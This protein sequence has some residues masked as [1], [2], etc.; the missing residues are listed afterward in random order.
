MEDPFFAAMVRHGWKFAR[1]TDIAR[2]NGASLHAIPE[3]LQ[4]FL[5]SYDTLTS[6]D[7]TTWLNA[8][9]DFTRTTSADGFSWDAFEL[10]SL[11]EAEGD[12]VWQQ[13]IQAFW[14]SHLPIL[15]S[16]DGHYTYVAYCLAGGNQGRYVQ[17]SEPE[18][19]QVHVV[20][21]SLPEFK[22]WLLSSVAGPGHL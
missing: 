16:V 2:A 5:S 15:L 21:A 19:E 7:E 22:S 17:G 14:R 11:A 8:A 18:F 9:R 6:V 12:D 4:R 3:D 13:E 1:P 20:A 10:M